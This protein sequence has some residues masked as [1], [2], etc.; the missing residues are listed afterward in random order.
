MRDGT[1]LLDTIAL[2]GQLTDMTRGKSAH[3]VLRALGC[4]I[5]EIAVDREAMPL[6]EAIAAVA[7]EAREID[8]FNKDERQ[9]PF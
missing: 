6:E 4:L 9:L 3:V 7:G 8:R 5:H 2:A 1:D